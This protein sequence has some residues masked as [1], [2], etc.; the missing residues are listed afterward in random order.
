MADT[1]LAAPG[2][3]AQKLLDLLRTID[4]RLDESA[5]RQASIRLIG[6]VRDSLDPG[7]VSADQVPRADSRKLLYVAQNGKAYFQVESTQLFRGRRRPVVWLD[8]GKSFYAA[9]P[10]LLEIMDRSGGKAHWFM[11]AG[12]IFGAGM[13]RVGDDYGDLP[14]AIKALVTA[15]EGSIKGG[16]DLKARV[17]RCQTGDKTLKIVA[18]NSGEFPGD[19]PFLYA[20]DLDPDKGYSLVRFEERRGHDDPAR[21]LCRRTCTLEYDEAAPGVFVLKKSADYTCNSGEV[22]KKNNYA[23]TRVTEV[24]IEH[25][26]L[27]DFTVEPTL[28]EAKYLPAPEG[29]HIDDHR[30]KPDRPSQ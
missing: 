7:A 9:K 21:W 29:G 11:M 26:D 22:A 1:E 3:D 25:V 5:R 15:I 12:E 10:Q 20:Y 16:D 30:P 8:D 18:T 14:D 19:T 4:K 2:P 17:I 13:V 24:E 23:G 27:G 28:F 6:R